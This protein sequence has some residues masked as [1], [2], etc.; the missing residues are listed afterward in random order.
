MVY[1]IVRSGGKQYRVQPGQVLDVERLPVLEGENIEINDVLLLSRDGETIVDP[2]TLHN[3]RVSAEVISHARDRKVVIFKYKAKTR[4]RLKKGHRQPFTR[5]SIK[6]ISLGDEGSAD[7][8]QAKAPRKRRIRRTESVAE[9]ETS[10]QT[11]VGELS[12]GT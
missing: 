4:Y 10:S 3:A 2:A 12:H 11:Q 6:T 9:T 8:A 5:L 1:A 7:E